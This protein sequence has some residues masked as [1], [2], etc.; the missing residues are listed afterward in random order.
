M[1]YPFILL[2]SELLKFSKSTAHTAHYRTTVHVY[3][4]CRGLPEL[5]AHDI[6]LPTFIEQILLAYITHA[7]LL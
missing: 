1:F 7:F 6:G 2:Y 5:T 3:S 4:M